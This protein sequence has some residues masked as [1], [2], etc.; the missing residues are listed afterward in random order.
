MNAGVVAN[1]EKEIKLLREKRIVVVQIE[2]EEWKGLDR[3]AAPGNDFGTTA[4]YQIQSGKLLKHP[5][6]IGGAKDRNGTR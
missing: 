6:R 2:T 5:N 4:G 3:R 1:F